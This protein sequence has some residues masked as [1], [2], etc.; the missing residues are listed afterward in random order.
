MYAKE[1]R[2]GSQRVACTPVFTAALFTEAKIWKQLECPMTDELIKKMC[3][4]TMGHYLAFKKKEILLFA[5]TWINLED[6]RP[7]EISHTE[8]IKHYVIL[9]GI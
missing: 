6:I 1:V 9:C 4:H 7:G 5:T 8:K 2:S 3:I